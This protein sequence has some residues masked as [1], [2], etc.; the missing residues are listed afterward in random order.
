MHHHQISIKSSTIA[1]D[2]RQKQ[3]NQPMRLIPIT[4][5][6]YFTYINTY[7]GIKNPKP[8]IHTK[9]FPELHKII[10]SKRA[11]GSYNAHFQLP[12]RT[13]AP[14]RSLHRFAAAMERYRRVNSSPT[15][16]PSCIKDNEIR[17]TTQGLSGGYISY[18]LSLF[19]VWLNPSSLLHLSFARSLRMYRLCSSQPWSYQHTQCLSL[20]CLPL[21]YTQYLCV[22]QGDTPYFFL[23]QQF[24]SRLHCACLVQTS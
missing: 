5:G 18:A 9:D 8:Y 14:W 13:P 22:A 12:Q 20:V 21:V 17:I 10:C 23:H 16:A 7:V 4:N 1:S 2:H 19:Q 24:R 11:V 15:T 3:Q 6:H